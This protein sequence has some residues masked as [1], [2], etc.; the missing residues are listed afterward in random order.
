LPCPGKR[1]RK[2]VFGNKASWGWSKNCIRNFSARPCSWQEALKN[3]L[4]YNR[5]RA[6]QNRGIAAR[7]FLLGK[8][9][10]GVMARKIA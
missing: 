10:H 5:L 3:F 1:T 4:A 6:E 2:R 7:G 8:N 9:P